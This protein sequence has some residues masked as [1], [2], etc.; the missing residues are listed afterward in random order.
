MPKRL[1][2][3][4]NISRYRALKA[5][6]DR[7]AVTAPADVP[8]IPATIARFD[9]FYPG[10]KTKYLAVQAALTSQS[11]LTNQIKTAKILAGFFVADMIDALQNA[12][13]RGTFDASVRGLYGLPVTEALRPEIITE[14]QVLDWGERVHDGETAR[15]AAGGAPITFPSLA[16]VDAAVNAFKTL[17]LNQAA[18]KTTYDNAQ[19]ALA[20]DNVEADKLILKM[21]NEMEAAFDEGNKPSV[22]RKCREWGV[23]YVA[24]AG[25]VLSPDE[26]SITGKLSDS[27]SG[28]VL[29]NVLV[30]VQETDAFFT[31]DEQGDYF[32]GSLPAGSYTLQAHLAG[33]GEKELMAV[34]VAGA[35]TTLNIALSPAG[36]L[37][38]TVKQANIGVAGII[39]IDGYPGSIATDAFGNFT[40]NNVSSGAQTVHAS[41]VSNPALVQTEVLTIVAGGAV[42]VGFNF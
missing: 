31:T 24:S 13:R 42:G 6:N 38:G 11:G 20:A 29:P 35:I 1:L 26:F 12:I 18:A 39:T 37:T 25:E 9:T 40:A 2:P 17:N 10:Y 5:M 30:H 7:K 34:V 3:N 14:Q 41:L 16:Q 32:V 8:I 28:V 23:V 22:R 27:V 21:W 33:F 4:S 15:I 19:E 36:T